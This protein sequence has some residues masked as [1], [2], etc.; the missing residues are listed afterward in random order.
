MA[1]VQEPD[2]RLEIITCGS[3]GTTRGNRVF[4]RSG[5]NSKA[6]HPPGTAIHEAAQVLKGQERSFFS[7]LHRL[8]RDVRKT[9][10]RE[11][12][13]GSE[14]VHDFIFGDAQIKRQD[15]PVDAQT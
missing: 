6:G 7:T 11:D 13:C 15:Y 4:V 9:G 1:A 5:K 2:I 14:T 3:L 8:V 10:V 12:V